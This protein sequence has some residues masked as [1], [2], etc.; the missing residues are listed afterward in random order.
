MTIRSLIVYT[1]MSFLTALAGC[2][3]VPDTPLTTATAA[4]RVNEIE[5]LL[6]D[7]AEIDAKDGNDLTALVWAARDE[8]VETLRVLLQHGADPNLAAGR[9]DWAP[10]VHAV[11]TGSNLAAI[12]LLDAG[13]DIEGTGGR[14]AL[15]MAAGYGNAEM[16]REMLA[17]GANPRIDGIMTD[18]VG[19]AWDVDYQWL[20]CD[21]HTETVR[22]LL[23][24]APDLQLED[25]FFGRRALSN[26][27]KKGCTDLVELVERRDSA[28]QAAIQD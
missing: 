4:G 21:S 2:R 15:L 24:G 12:E 22:A 10:L 23:E 11:H 3:D 16:V 7:G 26:A 28:E 8:R 1:L 17:R 5:A 18:A 19:G 27:K 9:K 13:A 6:A 20:G 14:R 25:D